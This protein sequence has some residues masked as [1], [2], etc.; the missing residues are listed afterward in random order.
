MGSVSFI[1]TDTEVVVTPQI[2]E[3]GDH[4]TFAHYVRKDALEKA[5]FDGIPTVALCGK[6][7]LP[8]KDAM[9]YPVCPECK[10]IYENVVGTGPGAQ[11]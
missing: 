4:D 3:P 7:W 2:A 6:V 5:I 10:D 1:D 9:R 8:T 11:S